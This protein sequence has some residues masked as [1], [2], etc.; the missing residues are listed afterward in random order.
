MKALFPSRT[1]ALLMGV[2]LLDLVLTAVLHSKGLI[3]ELNP[4]M[5]PLLERSEWLFAVVK[6]LTILVT[7]A[8]LVWYSRRN[9]AFVRQASAVGA[10]AYVLIWSVWFVSVP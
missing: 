8:V 6:S 3:V 5:R 4:L 2:S 10:V 7:Y 1:I 9:L